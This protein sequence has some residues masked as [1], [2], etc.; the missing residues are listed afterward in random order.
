MDLAQYVPKNK[1]DTSAVAAAE[2]VGLP[3]LDSVLP[4][5]LEWLQ[6]YNW[7]VAQPVANLLS[8]AGLEI[9]PHI[10]NVLN[11]ND[12]M[13]K[14]WLLSALIPRL[15]LEVREALRPQIRRLAQNPTKDEQLEEVDARAKD[16]LENG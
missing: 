4:Q 13:W 9:V 6:D 14:Y 10:Q 15:G 7:P 3:A 2:R 12:T 11:S 1:F 8:G 16:L 5:L